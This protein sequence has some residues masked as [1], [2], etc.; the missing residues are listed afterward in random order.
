MKVLV[1]DDNQFFRRLLEVNLTKWGHQVVPCSN[2]TEAWKILSRQDCPQLAILDWEMPGME[3]VE[4]CQELRKLVDRPYVYVFLLTAKTRREDVLKGL[5]SGADDYITKPFDPLELQVR[6]RTATRIIQ[7]QEDLMKSIK[8][9]EMRASEDSLTR[10]WNHAAILARLKQELDRCCR[11]RT[12]LGVIMVDVDNFKQINDSQG[13][14]KGDE[15]LKEL[16]ARIKTVLRSYDSVGR[17]GGDEFLIVLPGC[18][19]KE[20]EALAERLRSA[21]MSDPSREAAMAFHCTTSFGVASTDW[22]GDYDL[23]NLVRAADAALYQAKRAG[24]N[25]VRCASSNPGAWGTVHG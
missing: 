22:T 13:H 7:L 9:L 1:A 5:D 12:S 19:L 21:T 10:L 11:E 2:G 25:C 3:G 24:R 4:L 16:A 6:I 15:L 23:G 17:Y 8:A 18:D 14:Q 20:T